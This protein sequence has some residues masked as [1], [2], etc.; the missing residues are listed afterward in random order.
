MCREP[1]AGSGRP[2]HTGVFATV[3]EPVA[4]VLGGAALI[5]SGR[6]TLPRWPQ[7]RSRRRFSWLSPDVA[8]DEEPPPIRTHVETADIRSLEEEPG[9]SRVE[10]PIE[11]YGRRHQSALVQVEEFSGVGRPSQDSVGISERLR[12]LDRV[13]APVGDRTL[14][15]GA[16]EGLD[17]DLPPDS[18]EI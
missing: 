11:A 17:V 14:G 8:D 3:P 18:S 7:A 1:C 12:D 4:W 16:G 9:G 10:S 5:A 15:T 13:R 2:V 6:P